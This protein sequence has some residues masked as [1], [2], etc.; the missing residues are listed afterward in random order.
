LT[1]A[2]ERQEDDSVKRTFDLIIAFALLMLCAPII[3]M[4]LLMIRLESPGNPLFVQERVGR[5]RKP[6]K[7]YKLRTMFHGTDHVASHEVG[8]ARVTPLGRVL[9][10]LKLDELPQLWNVVNGS[11]S[12]VGPR[13]C[14]LSQQE[15]IS[16]RDRRGLFQFRP[17]ITGPAQLAKIDMSQPTHL[18]EVEAQYFPRENW[19]TDARIIVHTVLGGGSGD[20]AQAHADVSAKQSETEG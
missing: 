10:R 2:D 17:G 6:F 4:L 18:A 5:R 9:R 15:L 3:L 11:M 16:A 20:P 7:I 19:L 1:P 14:L 13:P 12:L 8:T